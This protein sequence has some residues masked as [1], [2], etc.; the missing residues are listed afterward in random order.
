MYKLRFHPQVDKELEQLPLEVRRIIK[1]VHLPAIS[2]DP[3]KAGERLS[4]LLKGFWKRS[5]RQS[6][7][8]YRIAYEIDEKEKTVYIL[9]VR[10]RE[11]FYER[12]ERRVK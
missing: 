11:K 8:D 5:F 2:T 4:G 6:R 1:N 12:L 10:K 7:V 9:M 3:Y